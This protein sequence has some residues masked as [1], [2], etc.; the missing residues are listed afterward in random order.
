MPFVSGLYI[1]WQIR[2]RRKT[3]NTE[4][5]NTVNAADTDAQYDEKAERM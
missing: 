5:R 3:V 1:S 2:K 4:L